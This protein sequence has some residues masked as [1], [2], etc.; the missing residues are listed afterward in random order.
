[1]KRGQGPYSR[2]HRGAAAQPWGTMGLFWGQGASL[3][4]NSA[5]VEGN[6]AEVGF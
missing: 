5:K 4:E 2:G 6:L 3:A 1:M